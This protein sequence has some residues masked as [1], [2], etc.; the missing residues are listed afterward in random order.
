MKFVPVKTLG[1]L[2][3]AR[4]FYSEW[5]ALFG[6]PAQIR[7]DKG[8]AF[9]A[10]L[11][12]A[13]AKILGIQSHD[14]ACTH[15]PT[16]HALIEVRHKNLDDILNVAFN[17]GDLSQDTIRYYCA[18][19]EQRHNQYTHS[20]HGHT[21]FELVTGEIPR[22][23]HNFL[24]L[25]SIDEINKLN[26]DDRKFVER[27]RD[28]I[29]STIVWTHY[30]DD[31]RLHKEKAHRLTDMYNRQHKIFDLR[32]N[33]IVSYEGQSATILELLQPTVTGPA[34]ARIRITNHDQSTEKIVLYADLYPIGIAYPELMIDTPDMDIS[35]GSFCFYK[36]HDDTHTVTICAGTILSF[37]PEHQKCNIHCYQQTNRPTTKFQPLDA[38]KKKP[39]CREVQS[40]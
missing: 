13:I 3:A 17:K 26:P 14:F 21:P 27:L 16:H 6:V 10:D 19:A 22:T 18:V 5:V 40:I 34:K 2:D 36:I 15:E 12:K 30:Q 32:I 25:P 37:T 9:V 24:M 20:P 31:D 11:M 8:S 38:P 23:Q 28:D 35:T 29:R 4:A 1:A 39:I 7:S 33:D